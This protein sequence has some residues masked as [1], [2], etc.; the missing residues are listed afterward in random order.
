MKQIFY[1]FTFFLLFFLGCSAPVVPS[2]PVKQNAHS[3]D[4]LHD[5]QPILDRRCVSCHSC[6]NAPCQSKFSSYEGVDRGA[7]KIEVYNALR[8]SAIDPTRLFIDANSSQEWHEKGFFSLT[9][10]QESNLTHND[11]IIAHLLHDKQ[12]H[13]EIVG[14]YDPEHDTLSCPKDKEELEEY[15][16][17]KPYHGMP[18]GFPALTKEEHSIIMSW[19][20]NGAKGP[21]E[22]QENKLKTPSPANAHNIALWEEFLNKQDAKHKMTARYLYEHLYLAH[23][24]FSPTKGVPEFYE[25]VRSYTPTGKPIEVITTLRPFDDPNTEEF[26]YRFRKIHSTIVHKTHMTFALDKNVLKR[27]QQLFIEPQWDEEPHFVSYDIK[28]AANPFIAFRQIPPRSRY[29]FLLDNSHYIIMTFI[30]GPVCRGQ[31]ALNVIHD[32]FWVMFKDPSAD[33]SVLYPEFINSQAAN[34][35]LP[36]HKVDASLIKTFS[37][38]YRERYER[39]YKAK[40]EIVSRK[41]PRGYSLNT[42]WA[43][44]KALDAPMLTVYRH[45]D[46][47]SVHKG[48]LGKEPRT[49][50]VIDYAQFE[51]IYYA[52]VAG[53]DV[54]GNVS[55]QTNIRRYMDFLRIERELNFL[56]YM[57]KTIRQ[58]MLHSWYIGDNNIDSSKYLDLD[59]LPSAIDFTSDYPKYEFTQQLLEKRFLKSTGIVF[60]TMNHL[61]PYQTPP[62]MPKEFTTLADFEEGARS[63]TLAGSGFITTM[64][65]KGANNI[66]VRIDL[67]D[68]TY[69]VKNLVINRW[70]NNVNS[71]FNGDEVLDASKDTMDILD[72]S[73]GSYPNAFA[74]VKQDKLANFLELMKNMQGSDAEYKELQ[75]FFISRSNPKFWEVYDWFVNYFYTIDPVNAGLYDLNR[76][77]KTP[78]E[79]K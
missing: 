24:Y 74:V 64:T 21:N 41:Y 26:Y 15:L 5:V 4:Y 35:A 22:T 63:I 68:G 31:M 29:Q 6:Y 28:V 9:H 25:L 8:L 57:P 1:I 7:S 47:A 16:D 39:Y 55:H 72:A 65:D 56:E 23:L 50:W 76:Y 10:S 73:I 75:S 30:R 71:L 11:S 52:L 54:F 43:G 60:D 19:L 18:Y 58:E 42:I 53:Y 34:L 36:I 38:E 37:D 61:S 51:R 17:D 59:T 78:W 69:I 27:F 20:A 66:F 44:E 79:S 40:K 48:A 3:I 32:H 70:H 77:A 46:S 45:F 12:L 14:N 13:P 49:L 62:K 33:V 67:D 2:V